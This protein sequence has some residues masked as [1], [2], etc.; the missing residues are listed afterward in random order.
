MISIAVATRSNPV[1]SLTN[2]PDRAC[3]DAVHLPGGNYFDQMRIDLPASHTRLD[4]VNWV[5]RSIRQPWISNMLR[6]LA[7]GFLIRLRLWEPLIMNGLV[8]T[9]FHD[10]MGYW[11]DVIGGRPIPTVA[12]F[13]AL[14]HDYRKGQQQVDQLEWAD[15]TQHVVNWQDPIHIYQTFHNAR[16]LALRPVIGLRL[17]KLIAARSRIL[18]YGCS[19]APYYYCYRRYFSHLRCSFVLADIPNFPFHYAKYLYGQDADVQFKTINPDDFADPLADASS[20]DQTRFDTIILTT[21]FEHLDDPLFAATY[22]LDRLNPNGLFVFDYIRSEGLG[23]DH[24]NALETREATLTTILD[25][26]EVV[27]GSVDDLEESIGFCIV[28]KIDA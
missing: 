4:N 24:P 13:N 25:R 20:T 6:L 5:Q 2:N 21:V 28:R 15:S 10:F 27:Y 22:L 18:E 8:R 19:L 11:H 9:W 1:P 16:K 23:L 12:D 14:L 3:K 7:T 17:W 26:T